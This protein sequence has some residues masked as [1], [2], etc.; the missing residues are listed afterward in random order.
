MVLG[1]QIPKLPGPSASKRKHENAEMRQAGQLRALRCAA[2]DKDRKSRH[3]LGEMFAIRTPLRRVTRAVAVRR[4]GG[5]GD[6]HH[7]PM[8]PPFARLRPPTQT[9][10]RL[11]FLLLSYSWL[12]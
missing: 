1:L 6:H 8:M 12:T 10:S 5:G 4:M 9:V 7:G 2:R 3:K 11:V